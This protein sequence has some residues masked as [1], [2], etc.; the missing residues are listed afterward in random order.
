MFAYAD[1]T[2]LALR[3]INIPAPQIGRLCQFR[4]CLGPA[5]PSAIA[6]AAVGLAKNERL[7]AEIASELAVAEEESKASD[8]PARRFEEFSIVRG[9]VVVAA[10]GTGSPDQGN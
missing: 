6:F 5:R 2:G 3:W 9:V 4:G 8:Q 7:I 10:S 1:Q